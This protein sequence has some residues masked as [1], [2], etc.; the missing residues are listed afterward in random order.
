MLWA[1]LHLPL[2]NELLSNYLVRLLIFEI[3][4]HHLRKKDHLSS[5]SMDSQTI[6]ELITLQEQIGSTIVRKR[7][8]ESEDLR[9]Q[10]EH[11]EYRLAPSIYRCQKV[12]TTKAELSRKYEQ[13]GN[14]KEILERKLEQQDQ[15]HLDLTETLRQEKK[16]ADSFREEVGTL[17]VKHFKS[18]IKIE[19]F[20]ER[21]IAIKKVISELKAKFGGTLR[22]F[23]DIDDTSNS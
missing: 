2:G 6:E 21:G 5:Y 17:K 22:S 20:E 1:F 23:S 16:I 14:E 3:S 18:G 10:V 15:S 19:R 8:K 9:D 4:D 7:R 12:N 13:L 11:L